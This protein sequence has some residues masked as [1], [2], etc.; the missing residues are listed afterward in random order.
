VHDCEDE[1]ALLRDKH[2]AVEKDAGDEQCT[3][4]GRL[5]Q[6]GIKRMPEWLKQ[7]ATDYDEPGK[8]LHERTKQTAASYVRRHFYNPLATSKLPNQYNSAILTGTTVGFWIVP[9]KFAIEQGLDF[10]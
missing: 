7:D 5:V 6:S 3:W 4:F 8:M 10:I 9:F 2:L 1:S